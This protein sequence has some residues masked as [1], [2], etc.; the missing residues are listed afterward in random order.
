VALIDVADLVYALP[1]GW[2]LFEGVSFRV[3]EGHRAALVGANGIGKSTLLRIVAG[4]ERP[5]AGAINV[6]AR[7]GLMRQLI[8]SDAQPTTVREFLLG[9]ADR[10]VA[11]SGRRLLAAEGALASDPTEPLQVAYANALASWEEAGGYRAEVVWDGCTTA[12]FGQGYPE[13]AE[14][15]IE[16]LSGGERKRLALEVLFRSD[17]DVLL[18]DEPDNFLDIEG[19]H[20]LERQMVASPKTILFVSHDR[21]V[22]ARTATR[23]L[24]LEA[25]GVWTHPDGYAS[26]G[27]A[28]EARLEQLEEE[29][30][31]YAEQHKHFVDAIRRLKQWGMQNDKLAARARAV[32][33]RL[34]RFEQREA[35]RERPKAQSVK[36]GIEGGRTGKMALRISDLSIPEM[37]DPFDAEL[38]YGERIGIVGPN[39][40]GKSSFLRLLAG[41]EI[42]HEGEFTL[43]ARVEPALFRQ[44]HD[45]PD[46]LGVP[47]VEIL[48]RRGMSMSEAMSIL[49]R[50]ELA[51]VGRSPFEILS[52]GQQAR[53]QLLMMEVESPTMLLLDEPTDNLDVAAADALED[54][55]LRYRGT[56]LAV[57]HD[58]WF[59]RLMDR[60][61]FFDEDGSVR[62]LLESPWA[63]ELAGV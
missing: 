39:G 24:T 2:T 55:I 46:L 61:L 25:R 31:R 40:S 44:L 18:L 20:W 37:I 43:G 35:P 29:H 59:M 1:G 8:G 7:I 16:T 45:R 15:T 51:H 56:V 22:L 13:C 62:E 28:R 52:G 34:A 58:R 57:T 23:V 10:P 60:F 9:Y 30:R 11:E 49:K 63:E 27:Q 14:R 6:P 26:Y 12:A 53:L 54:A 3:P 50:Y 42:A 33:K 4:L 21:A 48:Q 32:E 17:F 36:I 19:K 41:E 5:T 38:S 47:L